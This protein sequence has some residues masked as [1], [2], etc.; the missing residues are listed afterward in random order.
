VR[1]GKANAPGR[2]PSG[3]GVVEQPLLLFGR[4]LNMTPGTE[5]EPEPAPV[6]A[7]A[8]LPPEGP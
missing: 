1:E 4:G 5:P 8:P 3:R 7:A 6:A 2:V